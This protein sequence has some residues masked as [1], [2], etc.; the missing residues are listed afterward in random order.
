MGASAIQPKGGVYARGLSE[1]LWFLFRWEV[2]RRR[3]AGEVRIFFFFF[4]EEVRMN[5]YGA[6]LSVW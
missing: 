1:F 3:M 6:F 5:F 2:L 4:F